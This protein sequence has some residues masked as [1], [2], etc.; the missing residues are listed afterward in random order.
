VVGVEVGQRQIPDFALVLQVGEPFE[1]VEVAAV[2]VIPPTELQ[3]VQTFHVHPWE[4]SVDSILDDMPRHRTGSWDPF[5]RSLDLREP[6][7]SVTSGELAPKLAEEIFRWT[8]MISEVPRGKSSVV[9]G[10]HLSYRA[11]GLDV[12]VD[13]GDLPHSVEQAADRKIRR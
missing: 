12:A 9:M 8:I 1:P 6:S 5:G 13:T 7:N 2:A 11:G 3:K 10:E 4:S